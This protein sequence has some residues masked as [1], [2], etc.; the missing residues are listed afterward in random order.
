MMKRR[1]FI[2]LLGA[3]AWPIA[4]RAQQPTV[5]VMG[6]LNAGSANTTESLAPFLRGLKDSGFVEGQNVNIEYRWVDGRYDRLPALAADLV[7]RKVAVILRRRRL[8]RY[9]SGQ[10][11]DLNHSDRVSGWGPRPG[12]D[13]VGR[14]PPTSGR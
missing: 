5:P 11:G 2:T 9:G 14:E 7:D 13:W 3:A 8:V 12:P 6:Y 1:D 4:A 10:G